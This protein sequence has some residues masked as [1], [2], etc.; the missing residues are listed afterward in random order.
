MRQQ[1][2]METK[3]DL[4]G[5]DFFCHGNPAVEKLIRAAGYLNEM[6]T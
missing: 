4:T 1:A 2:H 5:G 3:G 6:A